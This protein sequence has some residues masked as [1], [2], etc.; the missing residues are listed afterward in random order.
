MEQGRVPDAAH[1]CTHPAS[2]ATSTS[3]GRRERDVRL[4]YLSW[5]VWFMKRKH[6]AVRAT[7]HDHFELSSTGSE[8]RDISDDEDDD[9]SPTRA[10]RQPTSPTA[11]STSSLSAS[12]ADRP[13]A[14]RPPDIPPEPKRPP[15]LRVTFEDIPE[16][17]PTTIDIFNVQRVQG[18]YIVLISMHGLV[19]GTRMELGRDPDTGG[20]VKYVVELA[21]ALALLPGVYRVEL[22]TRQILD[23]AV[24]ASYGVPVE[25]LGGP[26]GKGALEGAF[27][28]RLPCGPPQ[29]Y[30]R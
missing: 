22:L 25:R 10:E 14:D 24:D 19:R 1:T 7:Q 6:E 4:E 2:Q 30:L 12:T 21:S 27:I 15:K 18:L 5:R 11:S 8:S 23:P 20:Q 28:V 29:E 16:E 3:Y 17:E 9:A 26:E 13:A